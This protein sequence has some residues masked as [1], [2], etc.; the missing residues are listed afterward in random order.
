[1]H[2]NGIGK[3]QREDDMFVTAPFLQPRKIDDVSYD[4]DEEQGSTDGDWS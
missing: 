4:L 3:N 1:M 2:E